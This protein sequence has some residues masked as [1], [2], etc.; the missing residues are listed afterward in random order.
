MRMI[1]LLDIAISPVSSENARRFLN[2]PEGGK[3]VMMDQRQLGK[4]MITPD[5]PEVETTELHVKS[6]VQ[7]SAEEQLA[8]H[9]QRTGH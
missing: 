2:E 3:I 4:K 1:P 5:H 8:R 6:I 9:N 7:N